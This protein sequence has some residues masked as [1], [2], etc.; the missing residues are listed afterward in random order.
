MATSGPTEYQVRLLN[1]IYD[2]L[3]TQGQWPPY[4]YLEDVL[5]TKFNLD[6]EEI[7]RTMPRDFTT[8]PR[9]GFPA[10]DQDE[11]KLTI[12]G[13][14][15]VDLPGVPDD[16]ALFFAIFRRFVDDLKRLVPT[17]AAQ[18]NPCL[19]VDGLSMEWSIHPTMLTRVFKVIAL[20]PWVAS[21]T[22]IGV[23]GTNIRICAHPR[24]LRRFRQAD[25]VNRYL[26]LRRDFY[27]PSRPS[28]PTSVRTT[29][30]QDMGPGMTNEELSRFVATQISD[31]ARAPENAWDAFISHASADKESFVGGLAAALKKAGLKVWY[32]EFELKVGDS[33]RRKIDEGLAKS[34]YGIV[35]L[36]PNF[37]VRQWPQTELDGLAGRQ[38]A[39]GRNVILPVLHSITVEQVR[40]ESPSLAGVVAVSSDRGLNYVVEQLLRAMDFPPP[41]TFTVNIRK[42]AT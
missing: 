15:H 5:D 12:E 8:I 19:T 26:E 35:V 1:T 16:V 10:S 9:P 11:I 20:E 25:T 39:E 33:L 17:V 2:V 23:N 36:S 32:D 27:A 14:W 40:E 38:N 4:R 30:I 3:R 42:D 29:R 37:F 7:T 41:L 13:L 18:P 22:P 28:S 6:I 24:T 31:V 34:R 21:L